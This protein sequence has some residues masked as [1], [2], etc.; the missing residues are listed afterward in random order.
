MLEPTE[1]YV[2]LKSRL[3]TVD[4]TIDNLADFAR[5]NN[6]TYKML[7]IYNPWLRGHKLTVKAGKK[8]GYDSP[9]YRP[10]GQG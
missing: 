8:R 4:K 9:N 3:V 7:K 2:P 10:E 6:S 5:A 1:E